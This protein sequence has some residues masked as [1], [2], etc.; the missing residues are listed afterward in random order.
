MLTGLLFAEHNHTNA[1]INEHSPYLQ[2]HAHNPVDWYPWGEKAFEKAKKEHKFIFLSIGYSTCHWCHEME[3]ESFTDET[4]AKLLNDDFVSIKVDREEYPQLDKKYQQLYMVFYGERGGWPLSVFMTP[5]GKVF[6]LGTYIPKEEGYGSK[7]LL[8]MLPSF[9]ALKENKAALKKLTVAY[10]QAEKKTGLKQALKKE[11]VKNLLDKTVTEIGKEF[12]AQNGGFASRPKF[13][14]A[15]KIELLLTIYRLNGN[16]SAFYMAEAT[17]KKMAQGGIYDQ[18]D[19]G[20]FRYTTDTLWQSPHFEKMLYTNAELIPVY[21]EMFEETKDPL[22]KKVARETVN[23][24]QTHFMQDWLYFSASDADSDGEEGG[25]YIYNYE[26]EKEA[27]LKRGIQAETLEEALAYL[28]IEED[29]NV[30]GELSHAHITGDKEPSGVLHVKR[31]LKELRQKRTF[32]FVDRKVITAW[33]AMMIKALFVASKIDPGY[34][35]DAK[36]SV[37]KL[38]KLMRKDGELYHQTLFGKKPKQRALLEDHAF[39]CDA[40][41]EGYARTYDPE[42]LVKAAILGKEAIGKFYRKGR[43]YLSDDHIEALADFDD[44]YYT[45]ALSVMLESLMKL[46]A[47]KEDLYYLDIVKKTIDRQ[48]AVLQEAPAK[49][50]K[51]V[52]L[53]LRLKRGDVIIHAKKRL[54]Q[55]AQKEIDSIRY[56]FVLS[57]SEQSDEYLACRINSCFAHDRNITV[58]I[59]KIEKAVK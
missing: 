54:L 37:A 26:E 32:P 13:P 25:Y 31:Y 8:N 15:S 34:L 23:E 10:A 42:Y 41:L 38:W 2:Q 12:D 11:S 53:Y 33:N 19:G 52:H 36:K 17:V 49:V 35:E 55:N 59:E 44:R 20:F 22:Y 39:L 18:I 9:A 50:P 1:L 5:E 51:L 29:G 40:L 21:A 3:K 16:K 7:G 14:E 28:G 48:G 56:P 30:D 27:L 43:W 24:M 4:V 57:K 58:L 47:L 46:A 45:S 6:H